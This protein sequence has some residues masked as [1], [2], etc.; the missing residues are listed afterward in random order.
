MVGTDTC[1]LRKV[2]GCYATGVAVITARCE[3]GDHIG[4][5]V[6]SFCAVSLEPP[7][8]LFSLARTAN[9]L[10]RFQKAKTFTVNILAQEQQVLSNIFAR[11]STASWEDKSF[12]TGENGCALFTDCLA[13]LECNKAE[14]LEGGDHLI[15]L[16]KVTHFHLRSPVDPLL[17]YRGGYGTYIRDQWSK[18]SPP[19]GSLSEFSVTGWG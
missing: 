12:E 10:T 11:P 4:V 1:A 13:H 16:G 9:V 19:D 18:M 7:L 2:L 15:F 5:T 3:A 14:E 17:F 8:I 6:N